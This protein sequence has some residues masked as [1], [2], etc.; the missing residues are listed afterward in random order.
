MLGTVFLL[1]AIY[2]IKHFL[3]D[4]PLQTEYMLGKFKDGWGFLPPL[5][6]HAG[7]HAVFT[8]IIVAYF[9]GSLYLAFALGVFDFV[10]HFFM[11]RIKAGGKYLGRYK[12]LTAK[13]YILATPKQ[14]QHNKF[15]W[16]SL[17]L[18]QMVHHFTHYT[19]IVCI[20][21]LP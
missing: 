10:I 19:I 18:D 15:F 8:I 16:W 7:V 3:A 2:Q 1:L 12:A 20:I 6:A 17:G 14:K 11:D 9:S 21:T 4:F 5:L 13:E